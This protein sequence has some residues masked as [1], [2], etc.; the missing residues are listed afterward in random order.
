MIPIKRSFLPYWLKLLTALL[1]F[2]SLYGW[3]NFSLKTSK[4]TCS[5][6]SIIFNGVDRFSGEN[7]GQVPGEDNRGMSASTAVRTGARP[8][9][10]WLTAERVMG[11]GERLRLPPG[12]TFHC[13]GLRDWSVPR[14]G[15][16]LVRV[17]SK[18]KWSRGLWRHTRGGEGS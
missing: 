1:F 16:A 11:A 2:M 7:S 13:S 9:N 15:E 12:L 5:I 3:F 10:L 6:E 4:V 18:W 17:L 14:T 8:K